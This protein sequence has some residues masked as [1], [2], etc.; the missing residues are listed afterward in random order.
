MIT[1]RNLADSA[2]THI[3]LCRIDSVSAGATV[4]D[5]PFM[6]CPKDLTIVEI[7]VIPDAAGT[8]VSAGGTLTIET[9]ATSIATM[10][11]TSAASTLAAGT[12]KS[13]GTIANA[14]RLEGDVLTFTFASGAAT[15]LPAMTLQ[16]E[17]IINEVI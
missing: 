1:P 2:K 15:T 14:N 16:T 11:P 17:Y 13:L 3:A 7:G 5:I 12:Y 9:G 8:I 6:R 10:T 4:S